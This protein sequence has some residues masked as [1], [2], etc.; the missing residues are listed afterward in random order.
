MIPALGRNHLRTC[1]LCRSLLAFNGL[2]G[3]AIPYPP[4]HA[5]FLPSPAVTRV[6]RPVSTASGASE[7]ALHGD[8]VAGEKP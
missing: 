8:A 2:G 6:A 5:G 7:P 4:S 3:A 1:G